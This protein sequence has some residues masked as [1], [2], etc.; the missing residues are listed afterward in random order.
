ME[1]DLYRSQ[2][3]LP[4]SLYEKLKGEADKNRRSVN[5]ELVARLEASFTDDRVSALAEIITLN[6]DDVI[7]EVIERSTQQLKSQP[8]NAKANDH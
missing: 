1:K 8:K 3:R 7:R 6:F 2:F 5:A 4:Q